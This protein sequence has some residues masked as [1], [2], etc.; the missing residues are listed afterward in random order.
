MDDN[1]FSRNPNERPADRG[2]RPHRSRRSHIRKKA[3]HESNRT[4]EQKETE[5]QKQ[6]TKN[7]HAHTR[8]CSLGL[9]YSSMREKNALRKPCS[10]ET[11][12][13]YVLLPNGNAFAPVT[14][15]IFSI[16]AEFGNQGLNGKIWVELAG[17]GELSFV[18]TS[19][20]T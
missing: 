12:Q 14:G 2:A 16:H 15:F 9:R 11:N 7:T 20:S 10:L 18:T 3:G 1:T 17:G 4:H 8:S 6:I 19:K 13:P 5:R